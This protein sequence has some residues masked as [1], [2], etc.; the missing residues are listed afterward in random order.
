MDNFPKD[1]S[2]AFLM[3][4]IFDLYGLED[5]E[6]DNIRSLK[7]VAGNSGVISIYIEANRIISNGKKIAYDSDLQVYF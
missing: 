3:E 4:L 5:Q 6:K 1:N 2:R 7:A